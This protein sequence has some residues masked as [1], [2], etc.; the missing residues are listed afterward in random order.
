MVPRETAN[1]SYPKFWRDKQRVLQMMVFFLNWQIV[2]TAMFNVV[3]GVCNVT[4]ELPDE[5]MACVSF[6]GESPSTT[7]KTFN[8]FDMREGLYL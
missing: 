1:Y 7:I 3:S 5:R 4:Y 6:F 2:K 8:R